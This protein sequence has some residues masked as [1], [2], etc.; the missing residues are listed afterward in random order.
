MANEMRT[1]VT[2]KSD[3]PAVAKRLQQIFKSRRGTYEVELTDEQLQL[4]K[5]NE[6]EFMENI[7]YELN[8]EFKYDKVGDEGS[9]FELIN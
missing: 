3:E 7:E 1:Y 5:E 8:W 9:E 6:D 2:V 4:Y